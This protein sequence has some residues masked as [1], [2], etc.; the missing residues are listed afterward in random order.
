M[1]APELGDMMPANKSLLWGVV[2][3]QVALVV[4]PIYFVG[5]MFWAVPIFFI[6]LS[7]LL[8]P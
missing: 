2:C 4:G 6:A 5:P 1:K 3:V 8:F 7:F